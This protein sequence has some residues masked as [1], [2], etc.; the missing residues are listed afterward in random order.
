[1][2]NAKT[3]VAGKL[4]VVIPPVVLAE[5]GLGVV[6]RLSHEVLDRKIA[7]KQDCD[8]NPTI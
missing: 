3:L 4:I 8:T 6:E 1:L 5:L 7:L 2:L